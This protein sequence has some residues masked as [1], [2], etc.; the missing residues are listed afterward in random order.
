MNSSN[1]RFTLDMQ[2]NQSQV[3]LPVRLG[4]TNRRL[5]ITLTNGGNPFV[6]EDGYRAVL[7]A[8]K[9]DGKELIN[10]CIIENNSAIRYDF[11]NNTASYPGVVDCE[12]R[13]YDPQGELV[14]SP[15]F[16]IVVDERV[17]YDE[18]VVSSAEKTT[19]DN[20]IG[21]ET[22]RENAEALRSSQEVN[23]LSNEW[24]RK[25]AETGRVDAENARV[26]AENL[27]ADNESSR[28]EAETLR[29]TKEQGR[30]QDEVERHEAEGFRKEAE[31][32]RQSNEAARQEAEA[33]RETTFQQHIEAISSKQDKLT[34]DVLPHENSS[35]P[36]ESQGIYSADKQVFE[37]SRSYTDWKVQDALTNYATKD[38]VSV[39][40][41][42]IPYSNQIYATDS[43][44]SPYS[45]TYDSDHGGYGDVPL[46]DGQGN[47]D[48]PEEP[49][50]NR[51]ATS[52]FYVDSQV[53]S[54]QDKIHMVNYSLYGADAMGGAMSYKIASGMPGVE[55]NSEAIVNIQVLDE[56]LSNTNSKIDSVANEVN[57]DTS[58]AIKGTAT[59][60]TIRVNDVS[61]IEHT[62][63]CK[64]RSRNLFNSLDDFSLANGATK[65]YNG[66][67]LVINGYYA[68]K[69][70]KLEEKKTYTFSFRSERTGTYGGGVY[71]A[72]WSGS[73]SKQIYSAAS[74][75]SAIVTFTVPE[76]MG[77]VQFTFY[78]GNSTSAD[79][80]ATYTELMLEEGTEATGYVPYVDA[81]TATVMRYGK[82]LLDLSRATFTSATYNKDVNGI[83][84]KIN[85]SYYSGV[86]IDYLNDFLLANKGKTLT[87]SI[88]SA[89]DDVLITLL[90]YGTRTSGKTNQEGSATGEREIS[91][92]ISNEFTAITGLEVRVNR[93]TE[94][95][96]DTT[97]VVRNM[98]VEVR[99][100][101]SDFEVYK[102][103][104]TNTPSTDG[105]VVGIKSVSPTMTLLTDT[106]NVVVEIEYNQDIN[107]LNKKLAEALDAIIAIQQTLIGGTSQ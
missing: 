73:Q 36:V 45:L 42:A 77:R 58:N 70:I 68:S 84:C 102:E 29:E 98:Q 22:A 81:T 100:T 47:I 6:L 107:V 49:T 4:D 76:G 24:S 51:A 28:A 83:T 54:K 18:G 52:K 57:N 60:E 1:Y 87:F 89:I 20:I 92:A 11:T 13:V 15:R 85:N 14:T 104:T 93:K 32:I 72:C 66:E 43:N 96:T 64:L 31:E 23:R 61:P 5:Y 38:E 94:A 99:D 30:I 78:G 19:L 67:T 21:T 97:T 95:F 65:T 16:I 37:D 103:A 27:R 40:A 10:D 46:R 101:A 35:N 80:S 50:Y 33:E 3:S 82:N 39:K 41:D 2:S 71:I 9:A 44:G 55:T 88:D 63:K 7:V 34:F 106:A 53:S 25:S 75:R 8:K 56:A 26:E 90:I 86:R 48:V 91:F 62:V 17:I 59:G 69:F 12:M 79:T 74:N 105:T